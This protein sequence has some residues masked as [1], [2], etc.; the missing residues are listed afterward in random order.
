MS[1]LSLHYRVWGVEQPVATVAAQL[2]SRVY[3]TVELFLKN[4]NHYDNIIV[5]ELA[6]M[7]VD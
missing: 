7:G 1:S 6:A 4:S 5:S 3:A 2:F